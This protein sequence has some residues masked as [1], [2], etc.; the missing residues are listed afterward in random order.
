MEILFFVFSFFTLYGALLAVLH[1]DTVVCALHLALCMLSLA[2]LFFILGA[3]FIAGV[4]VVVYTGAVMVLFVM[5]VMLFDLRKKDIQ[6]FGPGFFNRGLWPSLSCLFFL[7]GMTAGGISLSRH[8]FNPPLL[9]ELKPVSTKALS[10]LL[11]T[12]Y[13]LAFEV[14]GVLLLLIAV[15]TAVLCTGKNVN[16]GKS[17][18]KSVSKNVSKSVSENINVKDH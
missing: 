17:V 7:T 5:V 3:H 18:S 4:Q 6:W 11:F 1:K 9:R 10:K 2:G 16:L 14:L 13:V 8:L 15:G 12:D